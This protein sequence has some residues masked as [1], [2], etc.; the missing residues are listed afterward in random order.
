MWLLTSV[1]TETMVS[2]M[3]PNTP[4]GVASHCWKL[5]ATWRTGVVGRSNPAV[6]VAEPVHELLLG[7]LDHVPWV[8]VAEPNPG[9]ASRKSIDSVR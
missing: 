1:S 7:D 4:M 6:T 5:N 3:P 9:S 8:G 2:S